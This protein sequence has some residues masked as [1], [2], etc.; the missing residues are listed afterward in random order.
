[1]G[2]YKNFVDTFGL[3]NSQLYLA[4]ESYGG[5]YV[6]YVAS[7]M[8]DANDTKYF[9]VKGIMINDPSIG[10][11]TI[12]GEGPYISPSFEPRYTP[13][14]SRLQRSCH[15]CVYQTCSNVRHNI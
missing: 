3:Q 12:Q 8:L 9:D 11:F 6:P 7:G 2:F 15:N 13:R 5:Y 1:M 14:A 4:G 10:G